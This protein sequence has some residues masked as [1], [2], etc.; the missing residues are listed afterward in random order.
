MARLIQCLGKMAGMVEDCAL[1]ERLLQRMVPEEE[2]TGHEE[3]LDVLKRLWS[4]EFRR[5]SLDVLA[6]DVEGVADALEEE[7]VLPSVV[8][9]HHALRDSMLPAHQLHADIVVA[10]ASELLCSRLDYEPAAPFLPFLLCHLM[11][12][13]PCQALLPTRSPS[14]P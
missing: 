7:V 9:V 3:E 12:P 14:S 6:Q 5:L 2:L 13:W 11:Q 1:E 10:E 8:V 4:V